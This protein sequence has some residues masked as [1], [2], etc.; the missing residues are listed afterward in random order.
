MIPRMSIS[1]KTPFRLFATLSSMMFLLFF[2]WGSWF[3]SVGIFM[4]AAGMSDYIGWAYSTTPIAAIVTP[5]FMGVFADRFMNA[6]RLQ[7]ILLIVSGA[8]IAIAPKFASSETPVI[9]V[10]ILLLHALCFMPTLGLSNT[11]CLKHLG[12]PEKDYPIVRVFATLG[13]IAAGLLISK[14]LKADATVTQFYVSAIAAGVVGVFSFLMPKTPP[15]SQ[16]G[17]ISFGDICGAETFP[18]FKKAA[19]AVF[20]I[21]SLLAAVAMMPYW[22][23][24]GTF[25]FQSG[26]KETAAFLTYGQMAELVVLAFILPLFIKKFG[27]K[28]TM[29]I[30]MSCWIV[31]YVLFS[32]AAGG[33]ADAGLE[34]GSVESAPSNLMPLLFAAV[35]LHGFAYDFVFISGYLY[36]DKAVDEKVRAQ[37]QGLL[38]VA[39]QGL[40]FLLSSQI[41]STIIYNRSIGENATF[42]AWK[43]F[44]LI[45][46]IYLLVVLV[47]FCFLFRPKPK[48][49]L[50]AES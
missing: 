37:A 45:P 12:D 18:Y 8:C 47:F 7:G 36:V 15:P 19:F 23:N 29:I 39:T 33:Y 20:M 3:A 50:P 10:G 26:I 21:A 38:T 28:W 9:F 11:I 46:S 1:A 41:F 5:F 27:I 30:G 17:R 14:V 4:T 40:G 16:G 43:S 48:N 35:V 32:V 24:G 13:W 44:W 22:A 6:E 49:N 31:R 25:L 34:I 42:P 2:V